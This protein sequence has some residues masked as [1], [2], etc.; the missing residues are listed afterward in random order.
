MYRETTTKNKEFGSS[1]IFL[2]KNKFYCLFLLTV[3]RIVPVRLCVHCSTRRQCSLM[4]AFTAAKL[5]LRM[6]TLVALMTDLHL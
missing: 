1:L 5:M 2:K 6:N 4:S 3:C